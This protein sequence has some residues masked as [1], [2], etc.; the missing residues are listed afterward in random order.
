MFVDRRCQR[1]FHAAQAERKAA[2]AEARAEEAGALADRLLT[3]HTSEWVPHWVAYGYE[4]VRS[5]GGLPN[6]Q[7]EEFSITL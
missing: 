5:E 6:F 3:E 7:Q 1:A 4:K 2:D